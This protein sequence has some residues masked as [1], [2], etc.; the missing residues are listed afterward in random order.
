MVKEVIWVLMEKNTGKRCC[1]VVGNVNQGINPFKAYMIAFHPFA[2]CK[3]FNVDVSCSGGGFL[4]LHMVVQLSLSSFATVAVSWG[5]LRSHRMLQTKKDMQPTSHAAM[6]SA[7]V[8][9]I[10][11]VD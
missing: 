3:V 7:S 2:Q 4:A 8:V 5:M 9:E 10:A 1:E 6:N 11:T